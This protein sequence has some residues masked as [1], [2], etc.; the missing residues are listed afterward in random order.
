VRGDVDVPSGTHLEL[1]GQVTG[2][3]VVAR[4]ATVSL[5]GSVEGTVV[6]YGGLIEMHGHV[7]GLAD[8]GESPAT[9]GER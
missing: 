1:I 8:F 9:D 6:N 7:G 2:D 5:H 4:G 3:L